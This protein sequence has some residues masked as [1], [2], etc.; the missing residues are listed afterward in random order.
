MSRRVAEMMTRDPETVG[1]QASV[2]E[3]RAVMYRLR[4]RHVPVVDDNDV[5]V[6]IISQSDVMAALSAHPGVSRDDDPL[7]TLRVGEVMSPVV[8]SIPPYMPLRAAAH[9]MLTE[10]RSAI[11]ITD[12]GVL[13]G[14]L[15]ESDFVRAFVE[16]LDVEDPEQSVMY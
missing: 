11:P 15:T 7:D 8:D 10:K 1:P 16:L 14:I 6:G 3:A 9:K 4:V 12:D 5:L 13:V 2:S